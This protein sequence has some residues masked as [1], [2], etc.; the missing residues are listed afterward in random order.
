MLYINALM[1]QLLFFFNWRLC[2]DKSTSDA[3]ICF[4]VNCSSWAHWMDW[5]AHMRAKE[6][7][8]TKAALINDWVLKTPLLTQT[9]TLSA[10][11]SERFTWARWGE[12]E[13]N[14]AAAC[15]HLFSARAQWYCVVDL[16]Y[17]NNNKNNNTKHNQAKINP[18]DCRFQAPHSILGETMLYN[19]MRLAPPLT[20]K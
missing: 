4:A 11:E 14:K 10:S 2:R 15:T 13:L 19:Y 8:Q 7:Y 20:P 16:L 3:V 6:L 1:W 9:R 12:R 17:T 5:A 18:I